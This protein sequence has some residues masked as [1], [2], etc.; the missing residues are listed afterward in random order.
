MNEL[1]GFLKA[2][3][4]IGK[5]QA[6]RRAKLSAMMNLTIRAIRALAEEARNAGEFICYSTDSDGGGIFL[7]ATDDERM[8][9]IGKIRDE[10]ARRLRQYSALRRALRDRGQTKLFPTA[11]E[12]FRKRVTN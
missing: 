10:C 9:L 5:E 1:V 8:K 2:N 11:E 4:F 3:G 12:V 7:A 6:V